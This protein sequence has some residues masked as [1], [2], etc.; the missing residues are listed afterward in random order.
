M[1][2]LVGLLPALLATHIE[3]VTSLLQCL[4]SEPEQVRAAVHQSLLALTPALRTLLN[5]RRRT[6]ASSS[7]ALA[8]EAASASSATTN[9]TTAA[10]TGAGEQSTTGAHQQP[11][12]T[13]VSASEGVPIPFASSSEAACAPGDAGDDECEDRRFFVEQQLLASLGSSLEGD[14]DAELSHLML[15]LVHYAKELF[16]PQHTISKFVLLVAAGYRYIIARFYSISYYALPVYRM[17]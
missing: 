16:P 7:P 17:V 13:T 6:R 11:G 14:T 12:A 1:G 3:L 9:T 10:A 2:R 5:P 8:A 4:L 15:V